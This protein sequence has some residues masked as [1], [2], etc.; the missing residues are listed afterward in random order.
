[1]ELSVAGRRQSGSRGD[2]AGTRGHGAAV[3]GRFHIAV[4]AHV[5]M[6]NQ[7]IVPVSERDHL[8]GSLEAPVILVEYGDFECPHCGRAYPIV[9][10][11]KRYFG[12][13]LAVVYRHFPLPEIHPHARLAAEAAEA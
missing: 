10:A 7:S 4:G 9:K 1:M 5:T 3:R 2:P 11:V 8:A 6:M 13:E 12:N